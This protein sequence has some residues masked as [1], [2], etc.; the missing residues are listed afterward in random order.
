[1]TASH[2]DDV[3]RRIYVASSWRNEYQPG[4]V[5][6]LREHGHEVYDF[7]NPSTGGPAGAQDTG[8]SWQ[9]CDPNWPSATDSDEE[10][11]ERYER[12]LRHPLAKI[13]FGSDVRA[14]RWANT[15][16]LVMPCGRSAHLEAGWMSRVAD[17]VVYFPT[18]RDFEPELMYLLSA[19]GADVVTN[20]ERGLLRRVQNPELGDR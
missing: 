10:M 14:M 13:G 11:F 17:L 8:F 19:K 4:V 2:E 20:T 12:M 5:S 6:L 16:V 7:R 1:M 18:M 15:C 9:Q 3:K